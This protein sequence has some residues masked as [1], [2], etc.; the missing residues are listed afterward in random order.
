[1]IDSDCISGAIQAVAKYQSERRNPAAPAREIVRNNPPVAA[2]HERGLVVYT[3]TCIACHGPEGKGFPGA[4]PP[5]DGSSWATG[6]ASIPAC[7]IL[8]GRQDPIEV[9][10]QKF[11]N[12]MPP[13]TDLEDAEIADVLNHVRQSWSNDA[14]PVGEE[15]IKQTRAGVASRGKPWTAAELK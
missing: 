9:S 6:D 3:R 10:G 1:V 4:F 14:T 2:V 7:I 11:E 12:V 15:F 5:L 8:L 13:Q